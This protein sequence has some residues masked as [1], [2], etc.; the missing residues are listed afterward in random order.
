[1]VFF[2]IGIVYIRDLFTTEPNHE[3]KKLQKQTYGEVKLDAINRNKA[4]NE[5]PEILARDEQVEDEF[6]EVQ[7]AAP[8]MSSHK[9][10]VQ[11]DEFADVGPTPA[12]LA[13]SSRS[14]QTHTQRKLADFSDDLHAHLPFEVVVKFC[15]S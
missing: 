15:T 9:S 7:P 5:R 8:S 2:W 10:A 3:V 11:D 13:R 6:A 14:S 4:S 1:V 12:T